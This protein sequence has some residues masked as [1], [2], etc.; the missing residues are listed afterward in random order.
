MLTALDLLN[1]SARSVTL[2]F[3]LINLIIRAKMS[4]HSNLFLL[5]FNALLAPL[6][7]NAKLVSMTR[8]SK[9][10][11][12]LGITFDLKYSNKEIIFLKKENLIKIQN[13]N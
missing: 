8:F 1:L 7:K 5:E 3:T 12:I 11:L 13:L 2:T 4:A 6:K 9:I 10:K